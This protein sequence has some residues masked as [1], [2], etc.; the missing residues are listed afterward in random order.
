[1]EWPSGKKFAF[2]IIDDTDNGTVRNLKP[3]YNLLNE[4]GIKTT[5]TVW[6]Y[7]PR[8]SFSGECLLDQDYLKF[9]R[10]LAQQGFEIA[11][12]NVG[13]GSF[14]RDEILSGVE[15]FRE[16]M[17]FYPTMQINHASNPDN[18]YWGPERHTRALRDLM[19]L[20]Y[21]DKREYYGTNPSSEHFWGDISKEHFKYIRNHTFNGI[22]TLKYDPKMPYKVAEKDGYSNYWF[23]SSD[24]HTVEEFNN[25]VTPRKVMQL[26]KENGLCIVYTH[27]ASGFLDQDGRLDPRFEDNV[28][29]LS[30]RDGWFAPAGQILD[31]LYHRQSPGAGFVKQRYLV[32]LDTVW[33]VER[34]I[35]KLRYKR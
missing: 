26:E 28:R 21:G 25:L 23:S 5:K 30:E 20:F 31:Y 16:I 35:K 27:F 7:P 34:I 9:I 4:L 19:R 13:S 2:T 1:M 18:I 3:V 17:G 14:A 29:F 11:L 12:H 6:V 15:T 33:L 10:Q 24:A 22:N 32:R 8:D